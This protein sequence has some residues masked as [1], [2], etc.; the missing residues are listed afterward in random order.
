[1][2]TKIFFIFAIGLW[3]INIQPVFG[4][5]LLE[6]TEGNK[7]GSQGPGVTI[8]GNSA[9]GSLGLESNFRLK[10]EGKEMLILGF[11]I[12]GKATNGIAPILKKGK[13]L[14]G[15]KFSFNL[16]YSFNAKEIFKTVRKLKE[17]YQKVKIQEKEL[18]KM[19]P[20]T[21]LE[22]SAIETLKQIIPVESTDQSAEAASKKKRTVKKNLRSLKTRYQNKIEEIEN[23]F[24]ETDK[25]I[26]REAG[27]QSLEEFKKA[28][29][30]YYSEIEHFVQNKDS[31]P[32]S[33]LFNLSVF[34]EMAK[35]K[36][37]SPD[38]PLDQQVS[39]DTFQGL[40]MAVSYSHYFSNSKILFSVGFNMKR[41]N[42]LSSLSQVNITDTTAIGGMDN[43]ER[44]ISEGITAYQGALETFVTKSFYV[45]SYRKIFPD[46]AL[47][48]Y[49]KYSF[50][51]LQKP[52][53]LGVGLFV[54]KQ[55]TTFIPKV[56]F[57]GEYV[58]DLRKGASNENFLKSIKI[59]LLVSLPIKIPRLKLPFLED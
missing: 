6:D 49:A 9:N 25:D 44:T 10:K 46:L 11:G 43:T 58:R 23:K 7:N 40:G 34:Y 47:T 39:E 57:V 18:I 29:K 3:L 26:T 53:V 12:S 48:T 13:I 27:L 59:S 4:Q 1:M 5:T 31:T 28:I 52:I 20:F 36:F 45:S 38:L 21:R 51:K 55:E 42:N 56:G 54:L 14:P 22:R 41:D 32:D 50:N 35:L 37:F 17:D 15:A 30:D 33:K 16:G 19:A 24:Y 2:K 8:T